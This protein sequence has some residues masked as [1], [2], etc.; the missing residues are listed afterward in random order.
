MIKKN[1]GNRIRELRLNKFLS[2]DKLAQL[3][4]LDKGQ[5]S[6]IEQGVFNIT[7]ETIY[8]LAIALEIELKDLMDFPLDEI[9]TPF[10]KWPNN[11]AYLLTKLVELAP[12]KY[13]TY[14][15]P[16]LGSGI[17]L[18][19]LKPNRA[20]LNDINSE[21]IT[22][23]SIFNDEDKL[24]DLIEKLD[25][26]LNNNSEEYYYKMSD[27][28]REENYFK[29]SDTFKAARFIYLNKAGLNSNYRVN[30]QGY[31]NVQYGN[32]AKLNNDYKENF[33][34]IHHYF[35][36]SQIILSAIDYEE[37]IKDARKGDFIYLDPPYDITTSRVG[38][39]SVS[40]TN[41]SDEEQLRLAN[42]FNELSLKGVKIMLSNANTPLVNELYKKYNIHVI[43]KEN[44]VLEELI[45]T[46]YQD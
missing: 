31:F 19:K 28:D 9:I 10:I 26:H 32:K 22:A 7:L 37:V 13:N 2:I 6:R 35:K 27:L 46:N 5:L 23:Y 43:K 3:S 36:N 45:I 16:F 17:L 24:N 42:I 29:Q 21:L 1:F 33:Q 40:K 15:E 34:N 8:K 25:K 11:H 4:S 30:K 39:F 41:F 18:F 38:L 20:F 12:K 44:D 14:F